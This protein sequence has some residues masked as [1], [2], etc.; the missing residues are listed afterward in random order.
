MRKCSKSEFDCCYIEDQDLTL[1]LYLNLNGCTEKE[2]ALSKKQ[3][4]LC[5]SL[6]LNLDG[7]AGLK[8]Y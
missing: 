1:T 6:A 5:G 8:I 2:K 3:L 4:E 7:S